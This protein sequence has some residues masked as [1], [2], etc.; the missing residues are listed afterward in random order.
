V[1]AARG[2]VA[3]A[4]TRADAAAAA[5]AANAASAPSPTADAAAEAADPGDEQEPDAAAAAVDAGGEGDGGGGG[6]GGDGGVGG[7]GGN[8]GGGAPPSGIPVDADAQTLLGYIHSSY[9][10]GIAREKAVRDLMRWLMMRFWTANAILVFAL[11]IVT[12]VLEFSTSFSN[13]TAM[14]FGLFVVAAIGRVGATMSVVQR[15]QHAVAGNVL[16]RDPILEL[17]RLRTGKN[18]INLALFSGAVF[19]LL[20][21]ALFA[22]GMPAMLGFDDGIAPALSRVQDDERTE[23]RNSAIAAAAERVGAAEAQV[24]VAE[25]RLRDA[26]ADPETPGAAGE[27]RTGTQPGSAGTD[28]ATGDGDEETN[29]VATV[30]AGT[31]AATAS[32]ADSGDAG[33]GDASPADGGAPIEELRENL[34]AARAEL[35]QATAHLNALAAGSHRDAQA[36]GEAAPGGDGADQE[37]ADDPA[38][39]P[40]PA[41]PSPQPPAGGDGKPAAAPADPNRT[42]LL[43]RLSDWIFGPPGPEKSE[44]GPQCKATDACDPFRQLADALGF[45]G[46]QDFFKLLIWAF[47]AGFAE[48]LVPDVLDNLANRARRR[49]RTGS[50]AA[51]EEA[52]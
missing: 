12:L 22:S 39:A 7:A 40:Q 19:A 32:G 25:Q 26:G 46:R 41:P 45:A 23:A 5:V 2:E 10:M 36:R 31:T 34:T 15:L 48:R 18:G 43:Q 47:I 33:E 16:A 11:T 4:Q 20:M 38:S 30:D 27:G 44:A 17:T 24:R 8:G 37:P 3:A 9:L 14:V 21:Y 50:D 28:A 35:A 29:G 6:D 1:E 51:E 42:G 13:L 49:R 52:G